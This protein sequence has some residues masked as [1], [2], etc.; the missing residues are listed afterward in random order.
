MNNQ[1]QWI[2]CLNE[3][4]MSRISCSNFKFYQC[5][6]KQFTHLA[7]Y[8]LRRSEKAQLR[9]VVNL[10]S[11][12]EIK[13]LPRVKIDFQTAILLTESYSLINLI[14]PENSSCF[15]FSSHSSS[16]LILQHCKLP[17]EEPEEVDGNGWT[18]K[19]IEEWCQEETINWLMS[20]AY[21][22]GQSYSSIQHNLVLPGKDLV[23]L[24]RHDFIARDPMYGERLYNMLH[25]QAMSSQCKRQQQ[26]GGY[27][28]P[29]RENRGDYPV[30][31]DEG[32]RDMDEP[33]A[34]GSNNVSGKFLRIYILVAGFFIGYDR[35]SF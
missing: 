4:E 35:S 26:S 22:L 34:M 1:Q 31:N 30:R 23:A 13:A 11:P 10:L 28:A 16:I 12:N 18:T 15:F 33:Q 2:C 21:L 17:G 29:P 24:S 3:V 14:L 5:F 32:Y 7:L 19:P 9:A 25:T 27:Y 20:A 6:I 8:K